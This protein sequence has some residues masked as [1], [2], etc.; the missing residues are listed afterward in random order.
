MWPQLLFCAFL[1]AVVFLASCLIS[2]SCFHWIA[3]VV[4]VRTTGD[5]PILKQTKFKVHDAR[6]LAALPFFCLL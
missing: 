4:H 3:V 6:F 5:A 2:S 1:F